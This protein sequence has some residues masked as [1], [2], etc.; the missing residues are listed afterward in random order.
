MALLVR[1]IDVSRQTVKKDACTITY[2][3]DY[4]TLIAPTV[5]ISV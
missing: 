2:S 3:C 1:S 5:L 4:A